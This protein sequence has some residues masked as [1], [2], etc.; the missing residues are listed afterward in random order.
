MRL[1]NCPSCRRHVKAHESVCPFCGNAMARREHGSSFVRA[2]GIAAVPLA[3]VAC[4]AT[5]SLP[6]GVGNQLGAS[7]G[8]V[9]SSAA[10]SPAPNRS[11]SPSQVASG[12]PGSPSPPPLMTA[13][14]WPSAPAPAYGA[15]ALVSG[16]VYD[17][18][19]AVVDEAIIKVTSLDTA[20][21]YSATTIT[22]QG[23]YVVN[24]LP[25]GANVEIVASKGGWT[26]RR[27]V[28]SFERAANV[29]NIVDFGG[30]TDAAGRAYFLSDYPEIASVDPGYDASD[31]AGGSVGYQF[32]LSEPLDAIN[33]NRFANAVR[34]FPANRF[35]APENDGTG[36]GAGFT[37]LRDQKITA[38]AAA[39]LLDR[40][41]DPDPSQGY[42][43]A[44]TSNHPLAG[45]QP[46]APNPLPWDYSIKNGTLFLNDARM[47]ANVTWDA[48]GTVA[49]LNFPGPL[50][51]DHAN[52]A[53]Y[54]VGLVATS[55]TERIVDAHNLQLGMDASG[56]QVSYPLVGCLLHATVK[57]PV[58]SLRQLGKATGATRWIATHQDASRFAVKV[59]TDPPKLLSVAYAAYLGPSSRFELTF[60]KP[61]VGY[62]GRVGGHVGDAIRTASLL[63]V[64]SMAV[65]DRIGGTADVNLKGGQVGLALDPNAGRFGS[66]PQGQQIEHEFRLAGGASSAVPYGEE[67]RVAEGDA[68]KVGRYLLAVDPSNP[69]TLF[70]YIVGRNNVFDQRIVE[71]KVRAPGIS[72]Q[73]GN[74]LQPSD[75]D[76]QQVTT[77]DFRR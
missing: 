60:S 16:T 15:V 7:P 59:E 23:S 1:P 10:L 76:K 40:P 52:Q 77:S 55:A 28:G 22:S 12:W 19:A 47:R 4:Q 72:D 57:E 33:Q 3:L 29:K 67:I 74:V 45:V 35:A 56:S 39:P 27:R 43:P 8:P 64:L 53:R 18:T 48:T 54:Q 75:A 68:T 58:L 20:V 2:S 14:A 17:E 69:R 25:V 62:N 11:A 30:D 41:V 31:V 38:T 21:P 63:D 66:P 9:A 5:G 32:T 42:G 26:S 51:A 65:S 44:A 24:N 34:I 70:I 49:K 37:D 13:S 71:L 6:D 61:L 36:G 50:V 73:A 46:M